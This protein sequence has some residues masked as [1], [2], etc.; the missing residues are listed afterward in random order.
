MNEQMN[1]QPTLAVPGIPRGLVPSVAEG[2]E[3]TR[4]QQRV[5]NKQQV[6]PTHP[7][8]APPAS[9]HPEPRPG[10]HRT[11]KETWKVPRPQDQQE[12]LAVREKKELRT[13]ALHSLSKHS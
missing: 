10:F 4:G 8:P 12:P 9:P 13:K 6:C 2:L 1:G 7:P 11:L 5:R 3:A